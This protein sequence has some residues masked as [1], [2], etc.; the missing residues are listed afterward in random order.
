VKA[1]KDVV[2]TTGKVII[3]HGRGKKMRGLKV[4][5]S[6]GEKVRQLLIQKNLLIKNMKIKTD[7]QY[8]Y[9]PVKEPIP[10]YESVDC[11][12]EQRIPHPPS[13]KSVGLS[14]FD[15][16]GDIAVVE[17]PDHLQKKKEE[18]ARILLAR[19]PIHTVV[20][21]TT[22]VSGQFRIRKHSHILGEKKF[23]TIHTEYGLSLH[24]NINEVYFNPRLATERMRITKKITAGERIIDMFCGVGPFSIMIS[25]HT[26]ADEIYA[27]D[28]NPRAIEYLKENVTLNKCENIVPICGDAREEVPLIGKV[29]RIIMNLP[30][31]AFEYLP[32]ALQSGHI[33]HYYCICECV[34]KE[35][36]KIIATGAHTG[37]PVTIQGERAVKSYAPHMDMYRLDLFT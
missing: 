15:I 35:K 26:Q 2:P 31:S 17:I 9:F 28:I 29:D 24:V 3:I 14:R 13:L 33:I 36:E 1:H 21:K 34:E 11:E 20:E 25:R 8:V 4:P 23:H 5:T 22:E 7:S 12:F 37:V 18:I 32:P 6:H 27:I 19:N 30:H 16:I 10:G